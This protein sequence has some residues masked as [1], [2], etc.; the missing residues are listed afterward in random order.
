MINKTLLELMN[1]VLF[2]DLLLYNLITCNKTNLS[3]DMYLVFCNGVS[4][5]LYPYFLLDSDDTL[6]TSKGV[7]GFDNEKVSAASDAEEINE[8][9]PYKRLKTTVK[10]RTEKKSILYE[11]G[12]GLKNLQKNMVNPAEIK[13]KA[14]NIK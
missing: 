11:L 4:R 3:Q 7:S 9:D 8:V 6:C 10:L 2:T 1:L 13:D 5:Y 12:Q 14:H